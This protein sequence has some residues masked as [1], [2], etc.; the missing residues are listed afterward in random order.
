[1]KRKSIF[2][3]ICLMMCV[4]F[5]SASCAN[6][7]KP[8]ETAQTGEEIGNVTSLDDLLSLM[9]ND[10]NEEKDLDGYVNAYERLTAAIKSYWQLNHQNEDEANMVNTVFGELKAL[11]DS[12]GGGSTVDMVQSGEISCAMHR[13]ETASEYCGKYRDNPLYQEEM[14]DWMQLEKG[15]NDFYSNLAQVAYWQGSIVNVIISGSMSNIADLRQQDYSQLFKGG[16]AAECP[17]PIAEARTNLIQEI[18]DARSVENP[19]G[20]EEFEKTLKALNESGDKVVE[21]LDKW[22]ASRNK[23]CESL[24]IPES[25]TAA[26]IDSFSRRIMEI[27]EN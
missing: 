2:A 9:V 11:A 14:R 13:Y 20:S 5:C 4:A 7:G 6:S 1:M 27:I 25:H 22:L 26:M 16:K 21:L 12:L 17:M 15:L 23:L 18:N 10:L 24:G 8:A 19:D 3:F